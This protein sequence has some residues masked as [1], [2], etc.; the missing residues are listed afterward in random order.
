MSDIIQITLAAARKNKR[1]TQ[2]EAAK[3]IGVSKDTLGKWER[4]ESFPDA[5][6]IQSIERAYGIKYDH[7]IFLPRNTV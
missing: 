4:G 6:K 5:M 7:L 3:S 2:A 1:M